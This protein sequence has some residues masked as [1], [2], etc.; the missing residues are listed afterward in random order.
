MQTDASDRGVGAVLSQFDDDEREHPVAYF[1]RKLLP[2]ETRY[3]TVEKECLAIK[4]A[5][6]AFRVY[7]LG[8]KFIIQTDHHALQWLNCLKDKNARLT[9]W[10][11]ALQPYDFTVR[12]R[13][14]T[15]NRNADA[16]SRAFNSDDTTSSLEKE[17]EC[18]GLYRFVD[19]LV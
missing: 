14:G 1:S 15:A 17:G 16:L 4:L 12:Y 11:L 10:S 3:S 13:T 6:H 7:L 9:R 18:E 5:T 8:Q 19:S 2:R